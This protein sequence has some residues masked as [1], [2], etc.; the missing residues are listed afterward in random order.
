VKRCSRYPHRGT[1]SHLP[2]SSVSLLTLRDPPSPTPDPSH[3]PQAEKL[4]HCV[5]PVRPFFSATLWNRC[6]V[7]PARHLRRKSPLPPRSNPQ[8]LPLPAISMIRPTPLPTD[9]LLNLF[10]ARNFL[11]DLIPLRSGSCFFSVGSLWIGAVFN[12]LFGYASDFLPDE[13]SLALDSSCNHL[14]FSFPC[15]PVCP[16]GVNTASFYASLSPKTLS[17]LTKKTLRF[18]VLHVEAAF[19]ALF[20]RHVPLLSL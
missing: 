13:S 11:T 4:S 2:V 20:S 19:Y 7:Y 15:T 5:R 14:H 1:R 10:S 17:F 9:L 12:N 6:P 18:S 16:L 3:S 8:D